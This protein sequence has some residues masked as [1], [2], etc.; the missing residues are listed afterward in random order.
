MG[1][2]S[3]AARRRIAA[4]I[5]VIGIAVAALAIF[6][7]GPLFDDPPTEAERA[8]DAVEE[9]FAAAQDEDFKAVCGQLT[10]QQQQ[11]IEQRAAS[12]AA[13]EDLKGCDEILGEILGN[14]LAQT[15]ITRV[16][17]VR[18]SGNQAV[19]EANLRAPGAKGTQAATFNL[20]LVRGDWKIDDLGV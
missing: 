2:L 9:F 13:R 20:F 11:V 19:V 4:V 16:V 3:D 17:S 1:Q 10:T 14:Q 18:V 8:Q 12:V 15:R 5:L 7:V 6:D